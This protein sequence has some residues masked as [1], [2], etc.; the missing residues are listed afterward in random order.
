MSLDMST[1]GETDPQ[2]P[3]LPCC[4]LAL[5]QAAEASDP[6][7][8][9]FCLSVPRSVVGQCGT[10]LSALLEIESDYARVLAPVSIVFYGQAMAAGRRGY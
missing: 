5:D 9:L 4:D 10:W 2:L 7:S 6:V 1:L 3:V 8:S